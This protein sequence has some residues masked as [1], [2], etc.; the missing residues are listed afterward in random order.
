MADKPPDEESELPAPRLLTYQEDRELQDRFLTE[1]ATMPGDIELALMSAGYGEHYDH[2]QAKA[3][4]YMAIPWI[5]KR[6]E[7]IND[8]P[9]VANKEERKRQLTRIIRNK[10][11]HELTMT[12][13]KAIELLGRIEGDYKERI[14]YSFSEPREELRKKLNAIRTEAFAKPDPKP[15]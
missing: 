8:G 15:N 13:L 12:R 7:E 4:E 5:H 1:L 3:L 10:S 6:M 14:E 11:G 9:P 2:V